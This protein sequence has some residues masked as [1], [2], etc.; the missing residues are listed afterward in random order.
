M[1]TAEALMGLGEPAEL[2]KRTGWIILNVT[3]NGSTQNSTGGLLR[4]SGNKVVLA[5]VAALDGAVTLPADAELGDEI[6]IN[7]RSLANVG[8]VF[9]PTG[10]F[11]NGGAVDVFHALPL[12]AA[13]TA[14]NGVRFR[15]V[16]STIWLSIV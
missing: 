7:N 1:A 13:T 3:T 15:K 5:N 9:P 16:T 6:E 2:A 11:L 4:G 14:S 10:G 12:L 8:R